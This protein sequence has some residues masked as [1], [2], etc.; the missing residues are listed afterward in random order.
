MSD[1]KYRA[2]HRKIERPG[3][4]GSIYEYDLRRGRPLPGHQD[5]GHQDIEPDMARRTYRTRI[6][7]EGR[8]WKVETR[9]TVMLGGMR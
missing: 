4:V 8:E 5:S 7:A 3:K 2:R 1:R 6:D 9:G